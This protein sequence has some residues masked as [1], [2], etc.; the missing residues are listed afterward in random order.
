MAFIYEC[1]DSSS[2]ERAILSP[3]NVDQSSRV[4]CRGEVQDIREVG[5]VFSPW[6]NTEPGWKKRKGLHQLG[7][8]RKCIM[9]PSH[10]NYASINSSREQGFRITRGF[11]RPHL[12]PQIFTGIF[13]SSALVITA[14]RTEW[15]KL[16]TSA[17]RTTADP[18]QPE[19][20]LSIVCA[21]SSVS[22]CMCVTGL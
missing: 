4:R 20:W 15:N 5:S 16:H 9:E 6:L 21:R 12:S 19:R 8:M 7:L 22:V 11:F 1:C 3:L 13:T 2:R 10:E 18:P 17:L 14:H